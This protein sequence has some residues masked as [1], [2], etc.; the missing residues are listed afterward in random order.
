MGL[1]VMGASHRG[2]MVKLRALNSLH[3]I[4]NSIPTMQPL[5]GRRGAPK[6][7]DGSREAAGLL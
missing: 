4:L 6:A 2:H 7:Q 1:R 3:S 5:E